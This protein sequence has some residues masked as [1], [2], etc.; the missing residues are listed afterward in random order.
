[1]IPTTPHLP[2]QY[3]QIYERLCVLATDRLSG[4][5]NEDVLRVFLVT[6]DIIIKEYWYDEKMIFQMLE[7]MEQV[8]AEVGN[9]PY[10]IQS[11][12]QLDKCY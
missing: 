9:P 8:S 3:R 5:V 2:E 7:H 12:D 1:M 11:I 10:L 6:F 4:E